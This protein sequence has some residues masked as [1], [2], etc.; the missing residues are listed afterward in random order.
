[1]IIVSGP[2][3]EGLDEVVV[4]ITDVQSDSF[5]MYLQEPSNR[6]G[7][8]G[9][10]ERVSYLVLE[11]G[12]WSLPNGMLI[13]ARTFDSGTTVGSQLSNPEWTTVTLPSGLGASSGRGQPG[14]DQ[15]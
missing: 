3:Y 5:T 8:H 7:V 11:E 4:R 2:S 12:Q 9:V 13:E 14:A 6:N 10:S 15:Q 1:M